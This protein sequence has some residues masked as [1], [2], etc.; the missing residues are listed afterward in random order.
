M[1]YI[2]FESGELS[3]EVRERLIKELTEVSADITGI[4]KELFFI[5]IDEKV[6]TNIAVGGKTVKQLKEELSK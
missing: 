4:P 2:K 3:K 5:S 6:D 1:P